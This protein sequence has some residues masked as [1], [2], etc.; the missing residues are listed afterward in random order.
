M[1]WCKPSKGG[2]MR[3]AVV[4]WALAGS[5]YASE[6]DCLSS[7]IFAEA[8]GEPLLGIAGLGQ[9]AIT[10]AAEEKTTLCHL[11]GVQRMSPDKDIKP[12]LDAISIE[13]LSKPSTSISRGANRWHSGKDIYQHGKIKRKIGHHT[14]TRQEIKK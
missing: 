12:Y 9:A 10:K 6:K 8:R 4:V 13:L 7:I 5:V 3:A 2:N 14:L 1:H 11:S